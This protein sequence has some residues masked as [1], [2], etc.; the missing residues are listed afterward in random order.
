MILSATKSAGLLAP[1]EG[2]T[3]HTLLIDIDYRFGPTKICKHYS[4]EYELN[5]EPMCNHNYSLIAFKTFYSKD[6]GRFCV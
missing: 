3:R 6:S 4:Y 1:S 5:T 2:V